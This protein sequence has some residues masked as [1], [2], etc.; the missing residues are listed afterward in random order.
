M[1]VS[2]ESE[3]GARGSEPEH[4]LNADLVW[5]EYKYRHDLCWRLVFQVTAAVVATYV[6]PYLEEG[7]AEELGY[8]IL[9]LPSIGVALALF[10]WVRLRREL[11]I[12][13]KVRDEHRRLHPDLYKCQAE[14]TFTEHTAWYMGS[15]VLLGLLNVGVILLVW[16]PRVA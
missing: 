14:S 3:H 16:L 10:G 9:A 8:W 5:D 11:D 1:P 15:L 2:G 6:V 4:R 12:L 13:D 7:I